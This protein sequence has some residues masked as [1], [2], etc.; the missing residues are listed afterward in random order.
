M[1][2]AKY[3][4]EVII[5]LPID[6]K[7]V[8]AKI[9]ALFDVKSRKYIVLEPLNDTDSVYIYRYEQGKAST[10]EARDVITNAVIDEYNDLINELAQEGQNKDAVAVGEP[11]SLESLKNEA[12]AMQE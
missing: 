6:N 2:N 12:R 8:K 3:E 7:N 9:I 10:S 1:P 4:E 5:N 11:T